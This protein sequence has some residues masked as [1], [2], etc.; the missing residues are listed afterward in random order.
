MKR[1][2]FRK[3]LSPI[4]ATLIIIAIVAVLGILI[5]MMASGMFGGGT[6]SLSL[7]A[8]GRGSSDGSYATLTLLIKNDGRAT[9][10]LYGIYVAPESS[11][12]SV[13]SVSANGVTLSETGTLQKAQAPT[14]PAAGNVPATGLDIEAGSTSQ[15]LVTVS[16]SNLHSGAKLHVYVVY[17]DVAS[18]TPYMTDA[19]LTL[20]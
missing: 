14:L 16:G 19:I 12:V 3:G 18:G 9:A 8:G 2:K 10:R 4:I 13:T 5:F 7:V 20:T 17:Y 6:A 15:V 1:A 11:I